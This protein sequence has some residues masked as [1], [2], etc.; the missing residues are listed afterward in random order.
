[1]F[2]QKKNIKEFPIWSEEKRKNPNGFECEWLIKN[3][4]CTR[5]PPTCIWASV[6]KHGWL[7][8]VYRG[9]DLPISDWRGPSCLLLAP[10]HYLLIWY[11]PSSYC[12]GT[13]NNGSGAQLVPLEQARHFLSMATTKLSLFFVDILFSFFLHC[14]SLAFICSCVDGFKRWLICQKNESVLTMM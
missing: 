8:C 12:A 14:A 6:H 1:M 5:L 10:T 7:R 9:T 3:I 13:N 2:E 11:P 4:L